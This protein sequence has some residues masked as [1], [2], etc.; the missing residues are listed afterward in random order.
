MYILYG[1]GV[2]RG[3]GP[4]MVLEEAGIPY[5]LKVVDELK[6]EHRTAEYLALNPAGYIPTL[7]TPEGEVLHEAPALMVY[8]ADRHALHDLIPPVSDRQRGLFLCKLFYH[9]NEILPPSARFFRPHRYSTEGAHAPAIRRQAHEQALARWLLLDRFLHDNG[10]YHLGARFSLLDLHL[11]LWAAYGLDTA[12]EIT[13]TFPAVRRCF[14]RVL[15][16]PKVRPLIQGLQT[17]M[18]E[19]HAATAYAAEPG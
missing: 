18:R 2:T 10:P 19:W 6:G 9:T 16:R 1:G 12:D 5:T 7:I 8:I 3:L 15:A 13:D 11:A 14:D 4:Q 17:A